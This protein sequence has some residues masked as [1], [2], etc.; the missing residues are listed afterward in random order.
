MNLI[1]S[2][3]IKNKH[4][5]KTKKMNNEKMKNVQFYLLIYINFKK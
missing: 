5:N 1:H 4:K 3:K 2:S